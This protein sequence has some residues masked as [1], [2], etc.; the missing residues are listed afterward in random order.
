M[1]VIEQIGADTY[2]ITTDSVC[3]PFYSLDK[4]TIVLL[5]SGF[6]E[7]KNE[8][9]E[10]LD[11]NALRVRAVLTS[12]AHYDHVGAHKVLRKNQGTCIYADA[13]SA[14][15]MQSYSSLRAWFPGYSA[16]E[17]STLYPY[18]K[19]DVDAVFTSGDGEIQIDGRRF[20]VV[21]LP[22]H[23]FIHYGFTTED[24]ILYCADLLF[25]EDLLNKGK[26]VFCED[27]GE[28]FRSILKLQAFAPEKL[29]MAH[30]GCSED[31][32]SL[33][34]KNVLYWEEQLQ[35][36]KRC[37]DTWVSFEEICKMIAGK[38]FR[39]LNSFQIVTRIMKAHV[40]CLVDRG[41][42]LKNVRDNCIVYHA[43]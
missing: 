24:D 11:R 31:V 17:L 42:L 30:R 41:E 8:L 26:M 14:G 43:V 5:D 38:R 34:E 35:K 36:T 18:M 6:Y 15:I 40:D 2:T 19:M 29:V 10:V 12:H 1:A 22:G 20:G 25:T 23:S 3:M 28:N 9:L 27:I 32:E 4:H 21:S 39:Y 16:S 7:E 13:V 33:C 37:A